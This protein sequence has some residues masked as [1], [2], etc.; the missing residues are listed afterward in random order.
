MTTSPVMWITEEI[1]GEI[2]RAGWKLVPAEPT[3]EM[4]D[5]GDA[6]QDWPAFGLDDIYLA[7]LAAAPE[8]AAQE[9]K[10]HE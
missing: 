9:G 3:Q 6:V 7:M 5:A 10:S 8:Y 2:E 4:V 1:L